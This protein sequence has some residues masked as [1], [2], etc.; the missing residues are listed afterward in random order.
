MVTGN[1]GVHLM[2]FNKAIP[3]SAIAQLPIPDIKQLLFGNESLGITISLDAKIRANGFLTTIGLT[4]YNPSNIPLEANDM[5]CSIYGLTG[6]NQKMIAQ[7]PMGPS[8]LESKKQDYLETQILIPYL[9]LLTAG[10]QKILPDLFVIRL[11]GNFS[12]AGVNQ[13]IPVS[14]DATINPHLIQ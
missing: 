13:S 5:L 3:L 6:E 4:L 8:T 12:I 10:T 14:L 11:Q 7:Q 1:A 9:K 2:G